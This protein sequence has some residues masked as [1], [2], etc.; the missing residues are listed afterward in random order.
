[1]EDIIK[2]A[3]GDAES[4]V[5]PDDEERVLATWKA[6]KPSSKLNTQRLH[7]EM[8][9]LYDQYCEEAQGARRFMLK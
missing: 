2:A 5:T 6:P 7:R 9:D 4:L 8:P 3:M 1:M